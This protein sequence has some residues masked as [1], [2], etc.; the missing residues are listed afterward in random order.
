M[1]TARTP[2]RSVSGCRCTAEHRQ[3]WRTLD[4]LRLHTKRATNTS[5]NGLV[6]SPGPSRRL[7]QEQHRRSSAAARAASGTPAGTQQLVPLPP[8]PNAQPPPPPDTGERDRSDLYKAMGVGA[9]V[10]VIAGI[11]DHQAVED[12]QG[13]A[14]ALLFC[15]GYAGIIAE[16]LLGFNKAGVALGTAVSL[17]I[18]R[19]T[20]SSPG[21]VDNELSLALMQ[22]SELIYFIIGAM[23]VVEVVDAHG[24]FKPLAAVV[25]SPSGSRAERN[26][27]LLWGVGLLT[28]FLSAM[29]DNLTTTIVMLSV[30]QRA[31]PN[32]HE[33]RKLLGAIV[34]IAANSGGAWT[35]IG[36]VTTTMLW[37]HGQLTPLPTMRDLLLPSL[38]SLLV[39]LSLLQLSAP[40]FKSGNDA[41]VADTSIASS[42]TSGGDS[43][44]SKQGEAA[45]SVAERLQPDMFL[46]LP[47]A[48]STEGSSSGGSTAANGVVIEEVIAF[49]EASKRGPLV[50]VVGLGAL[51]FVPGFKYLTGLP[52]YMGML[53]GLSVLWLLTDAL[54]F[55]ESRGYP[56]VTD[57]LRKLDIEAVMFFLGILLAVG[58]LEAAGILQRLAV[59]LSATIPNVGIVAAAIG[60]VSAVVDNVPL[61]AATQGM[62]DLSLVPPDSQ[63]WQMIALAAGTGGSLLV[64]GSAAG[65][66]F[67]S[68][69]RVGFGWYFRCV[70][71][72]ALA[73][74]GAALSTYSLLHG[75]PAN[76]AV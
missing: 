57:A 51:L 33:L 27:K 34:V 40:E 20:G 44:G 22:V 11:L 30:L 52:P 35:P 60:L 69:E 65:V 47:G 1:H 3:Q 25:N 59:A 55:G 43:G 24:G 75:L 5:T 72:W 45:A 48:A 21:V 9:V 26:T 63:L 19:S 14:M 13:L 61:V 32:D 2:S 12:H 73:G 41:Q 37:L 58:A 23:T 66:A 6:D 50:L 53:C 74:Y 28:F 36:D 16:D 7:G 17:W 18:I 29:L 49:E 8:Q 64:I 62:Y 54:H 42:S 10:C 31:M 39:P 46:S 71:P 68:I 15:L 38:V 70:S 4:N 56:R 67:M 76:G